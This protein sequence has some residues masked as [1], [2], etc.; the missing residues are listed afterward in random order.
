MSDDQTLLARIQRLEDLEEINRLFLEYRRHLDAR[1]MHA[2]S[3]LFCED[4][5][6][7]G[8]TGSAVGPAQIQEMLEANLSPNPPAP[9]A[10]SWHIVSN[11]TI[12]L[13]GDRA[14]AQVTWSLIRRGGDDEPVLTLLGHYDDVLAREH[15]RWRF[16]RRQAHIDI[17]H[18]PLSTTSEGS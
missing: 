15:G 7:S 12:E 13:D 10:T 18:H 8:R 1:D 9:G 2:Y 4:G 11:P 16:K 3:Q 6:W 17:P 14:T 5:E